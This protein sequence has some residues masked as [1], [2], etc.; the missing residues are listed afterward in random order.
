ME[1]LTKIKNPKLKLKKNLF[2]QLQKMVLVK[3][4]HITTTELL[5]EVAKA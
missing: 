1:K 3:E 2:Y 5:I 4:V